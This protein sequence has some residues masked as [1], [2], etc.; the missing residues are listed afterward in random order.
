MRERWARNK[1]NVERRKASR[2][3]IQPFRMCKDAL[4]T[5]LISCKPLI[6]VGSPNLCR[7][8]LNSGGTFQ[9]TFHNCF[10]SRTM[11]KISHI[12][13]K[14]FFVCFAAIEGII[15]WTLL[16]GELA[17]SE[18]EWVQEKFLPFSSLRA[19][20]KYTEQTKQHKK[21]FISRLLNLMQPAKT[22]EKARTFDR[23]SIEVRSF[24]FRNVTAVCYRGKFPSSASVGRSD[25]GLSEK[26]LSWNI[27][28]TLITKD[29]EK[30]NM[31]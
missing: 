8:R 11:R 31:C 27:H 1:W 18:I 16:G 21:V 24:V 15:L 9:R 3:D 10:P 5:K 28:K 29:E 2:T 25:G 22:A 12:E 30:K 7:L 26:K 4:C 20:H 19:F 6:S 23:K 13:R 17:G 14:T